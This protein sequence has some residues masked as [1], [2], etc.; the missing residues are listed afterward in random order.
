MTDV[1]P[2]PQLSK[3]QI[4]TIFGGVMAGMFLSA[5]EGTI[6]NTA[7]ATIV[8]DLGGVKS[9]AWVGTAYLLTQTASTPL[10]GK[11]S[12]L[13]G[14]RRLFQIA[15]I[16]FVVGSLLCGISQSMLQLILSR[17]VQGIGGGGLFSLSFAIIGDVV[18]PRERGRYVGFIT[19]VFTV[20]SVIGPLIGGFIV[21]NTSWRWIFLLNLPLGLIALAITDRALRLPFTKVERKVDYRGAFLLVVSVSS[22]IVALAWSSDE[23]GWTHPSTLGLLLTAATGA[24]TFVRWELRAPEPIIPMSMFSI[25]VVRTVIPMMFLV[26]TVFYGTNAFLPLYLQGVTGVSPTN[27]GL[28]LT[29]LA[30]AVAFS[31]TLIGR[32]TSKTGSYKVWPPFGTI[33]TLV[34]LLVLTT[35]G[36]SDGYIVVA[37]I[38]S[39]LIGIGLGALMPTGTLAVQNAVQPHEMGT[40]SSLV[41][42]MRSL[43]GVIGL[44]VYGALFNS[45]I[46]GRIDEAL[47]RRPRAIADLPP[48]Q[49]TLALG[50]MADAITIVFWAAVPIIIAATIIAFRVPARP[51]RSNSAMQPGDSSAS[52]H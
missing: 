26:G 27:S 44:A 17:G 38:G 11:L 8:G 48:E 28:L 35:L 13:Y 49:K 6:I 3:R 22:L 42:F 51:L 14:R 16:T 7:L 30:V 2:I 47:I 23:N 15:I 12:D 25:D 20:T 50:V 40:A 19:S 31:A 5:L 34:A 1:A 36:P 37:M 21:D 10:F 43:G 46:S 24:I 45:R 41:L 9:Y 4:Y 39:A 18:A 52:S 33:V 32:R 29:P